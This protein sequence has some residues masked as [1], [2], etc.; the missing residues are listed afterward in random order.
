MSGDGC[1]DEGNVEFGYVCFDNPYRSIGDGLLF[2]DS[3]CILVDELSKRD[4]IIAE[5]CGWLT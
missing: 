3:Y 4:D 2:E 1:D 5:V